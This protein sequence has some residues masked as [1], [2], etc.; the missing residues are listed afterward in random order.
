MAKLFSY[1]CSF[2]KGRWP[3]WPEILS[4]HYGLE[5]VNRAKQSACNFFIA[6]RLLSDIENNLIGQ[7]DK[8]IIMWTYFNRR[9]KIISDDQFD[10][11]PEQTDEKLI[12]KNWEDN[13][14][15]FIQVDDILKQKNLDY[16]YLLAYPLTNAGEMH[17][18][19]KKFPRIEEL[20]FIT[21]PSIL[22]VVFDNNFL[23]R[24]D[25]ALSYDRLPSSIVKNVRQ[26]AAKNG[27]TEVEYI[28]SQLQKNDSRFIVFWEG[29]HTIQHH[30]EYL[31]NVYP[32]YV[33]SNELID[34][35]NS[36][37]KKILDTIW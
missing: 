3:T 35:I 16:D 1:G 12:P 17:N 31:Q 8:V 7:Q 18:K 34:W 23:S 30:F 29:H 15:I 6:R 14:D 33:W 5:L 26:Q 19:I 13:V 4:K 9:H 28:R 21:N 10:F 37:N 36:E 24:K 27:T 2:T 22:E 25:F 20:N 32:D 11:L